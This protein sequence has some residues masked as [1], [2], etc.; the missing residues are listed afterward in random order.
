MNEYLKT[1]MYVLNMKAN[2]DLEKQ[3]SYYVCKERKLGLESFITFCSSKYV[4][5]HVEKS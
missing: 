4:F 1:E 3:N 5:I 2:N